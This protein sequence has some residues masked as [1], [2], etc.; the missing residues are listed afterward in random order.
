ME[1]RNQEDNRRAGEV[2]I[3]NQILRGAF[4]CFCLVLFFAFNGEAQTLA[5]QPAGEEARNLP[6]KEKLHIYLLMGQSN[7][8]GRGK[9]EAID[10]RQDARILAFN[11]D[12]R[13]SMASE[14]LH[15]DKPEIAG[16][17]P[18][19]SFARTMA[20]K[21]P[22]ITIGL[23]PCAFG[24]T[25]LSRWEKGSDLYKATVE[26]AKAAAEFGTLKGVLWHQGEGDAN[27]TGAPTYGTR[28][29]KMISDFR[30]DVGQYQ[31]PFV[32][33]ELGEFCVNR[34]DAHARTINI[35]L[36]GV[37]RKMPVSACVSAKNLKDG[38]DVLHFDAASQREFGKR[39]A[40]A[41]IILLKSEMAPPPPPLRD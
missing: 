3:M 38:G 26:R 41:I 5:N 18:G 31:L 25:P 11:R 40:E 33:G 16:V 12:N 24:D 7:M 6:P 14:P 30:H 34:S 8:A 22:D 9:V 4:G 36:Q 37:P 39:Y 17:G 29:T 10:R 21:N 13:W 20:E 15:W 32:V 23:V 1:R 2:K 28:L 19:L 27:A 35:A